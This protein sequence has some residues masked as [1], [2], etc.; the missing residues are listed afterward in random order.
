MC[1]HFGRGALFL[2][3]GLGLAA[4]DRGPARCSVEGKVSFR[5][6]PLTGCDVVFFSADAGG[7]SAPLDAQGAFRVDGFLAPADYVVTFVTPAPPPSAAPTGRPPAPKVP[8]KYRHETTSD[9]RARVVPGENHVD[10]ELKP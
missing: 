9:L 4:C 3:L 5:G 10:F 7:G 8:D 6:Q 1:P 2:L